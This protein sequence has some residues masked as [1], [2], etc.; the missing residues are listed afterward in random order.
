MPK[1][2]VIVPTYNRAAFLPA[3]IESILGQ[4]FQD[5]EVLVID[6]GSTD[7]TVEV[8]RTYHEKVTYI[9]QENQWVSAAR[10]TGIEASRG[11]YLAFLD[12]DDLFLPDKLEIQVRLL[13]ERPEIG[14]VASGHEFIDEEGQLLQIP[15]FK[16]DRPTITLESILFGGLAP[17]HAVLIRRSWVNQ[18]NGFD[19]KFPYAEDPDL[20]YRLAL[21]GC[22]M[23]WESSVVCQYRVH[24]NN[25][26][27]SPKIHFQY[28]RQALDKAFADPRLPK[29][30]LAL[31]PELDANLDLSEASRLIAGGWAKGASE[32][33]LR[34]VSTNPRLKD[35]NGFGLAEMVIG[36]QSS[37][38]GDA[39]FPEFVTEVMA[40]EIPALDHTMAVVA[41]KKRF[42]GAF[43]ERQAAEVRRSWLEIAR[44]DP[45]WLLN[46]GGWSIL[47]QSL[48]SYQQ[49]QQNQPRI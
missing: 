33:V 6:D 19:P 48:L 24:A 16:T 38:W 39:R 28:A 20:W 21:E 27:N 43:D 3:A 14:L 40:D 22:P 25:A 49:K 45:R 11:E 42:Y 5:F 1:V 26:T 15:N 10:N 4:S 46:R 36:L 23:V 29:E 9:Y 35:E 30:L 37:V 44:H 47:R 32:R 31:R 13:D 2:S 34:A 12:S 41:A 8:L 17:V 7:S 18:V